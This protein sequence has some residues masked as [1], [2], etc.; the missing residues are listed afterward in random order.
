[1]VVMVCRDGMEGM[2]HKEEVE[3]RETLEH[4]DHQ[5]SRVLQAL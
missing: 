2:G 1:M 4:G 3:R 5:E